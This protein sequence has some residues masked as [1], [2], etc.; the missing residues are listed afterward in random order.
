MGGVV[1]TVYLEP[2][3]GQAGG[4]LERSLQVLTDDHA[5]RA[6]GPCLNGVLAAVMTGQLEPQLMQQP[7][8]LSEFGGAQ[9]HE[10]PRPR[11][12]GVRQ[13]AQ[14]ERLTRGVLPRR[15][16]GIRGPVLEPPQRAQPIHGGAVDVRL[17]EGI[18]EDL[19]GDRTRIP[20]YMQPSEHAHQIEVPL[21]REHA[22]VS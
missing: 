20:T 13:I 19:Q 18:V 17:P 16:H 4:L 9:L 11:R 10:I 1:G 8:G 2:Q 15:A 3:G 14:H 12:L 22:V 7:C 5:N 21:A 6:L